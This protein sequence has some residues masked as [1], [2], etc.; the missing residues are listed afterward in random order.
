MTPAPPE[1][2]NARSFSGPA[3][4]AVPLS[5]APVIVRFVTVEP[6]VS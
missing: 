6:I 1:I 3:S 4:I 5:L 2:M